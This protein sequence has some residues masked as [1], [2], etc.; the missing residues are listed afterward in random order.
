M[1]HKAVNREIEVILENKTFSDKR[2]HMKLLISLHS[3]EFS[4]SSDGYYRLSKDIFISWL[5]F[6]LYIRKVSAGPDFER[7]KARTKDIL[8]GEIEQ[9]KMNI[10]ENFTYSEI[11]DSPDIQEAY[12]K[13]D[14]LNRAISILGE[15]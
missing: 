2:A 9:E 1:S 7:A 11:G 3:I 5:T 6:L 12:A 15:T 14:L 4:D 13:I 8:L 10:L